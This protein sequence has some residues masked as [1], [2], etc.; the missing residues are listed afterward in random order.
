MSDANNHSSPAQGL[1]TKFAA[2]GA[3]GSIGGP[4]PLAA[5]GG[6]E[7]AGSLAWAARINSLQTSRL[8]PALREAVAEKQQCSAKACVAPHLRPPAP[9][10]PRSRP[11]CA[12]FTPLV[13][14]PFRTPAVIL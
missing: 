9:A 12:P 8:T 4:P 11:S 7:A 2:A 1:E 14:R 5:F 10:I 13:L 6:A 3:A